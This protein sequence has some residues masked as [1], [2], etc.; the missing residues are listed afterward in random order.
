M[1]T[2]TQD[3]YA[4][5]RHPDGTVTARRNRLA[6]GHSFGPWTF[7]LQTGEGVHVCEV[8]GEEE[9]VNVREEG[10]P[11]LFLKETPGDDARVE[12]VLSG[13]ES[14]FACPAFL[15]SAESTEAGCPDVFTLRLCGDSAGELPLEHTFPGWQTEDQY[16]LTACCADPSAVRSLTVAALWR[17]AAASREDLPE[18]LRMLPLL[19]GTDGFPVTVWLN[20]S[21][22]GLY[23]LRPRFSASL[24][25]MYRDENAAIAVSDSRRAEL[26][27]SADPAG[28]A[29]TGWW[30]VVWKG[31]GSGQPGAS[32][33]N[34]LIHYVCES[35]SP[36]FFN[37]LSRYVDVDAAIDACLLSCA[38]GLT[39]DED[40]VMLYYGDQW[41]PVLC[42]TENSFGAA[43]GGFAFR[44]A[45]ENLP[46]RTK[47]GWQSGTGSLLFDRLLNVFEE[48]AVARYQALR[49]TV[50]S[51]EHILSV[52]DG[53]M[54]QIPPAAYALNE[55]AEPAAL[56]AAEERAR[57]AAY[58]RERLPLLD[59]A[60][61]GN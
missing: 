25:G 41:I 17:R 30:S 14:D 51:Q 42:G 49:Q 3:G 6:P 43:E 56:S 45:S 22:S 13:S 9:R 24:F 59:A 35:D 31:S 44:A 53:E 54:G 21:F 27:L 15:I 55:L 34:Q 40:P 20:G 7:D 60:F 12:A 8:C 11:R 28:V 23:I 4:L 2:C 10:L 29:D 1:P 48:R 32:R 38:L 46:E 33:L 58:L 16:T 36:T 18:R 47:D 37:T 5:M 57:I 50:L 52:I 19:G 26:G 39:G 61:G